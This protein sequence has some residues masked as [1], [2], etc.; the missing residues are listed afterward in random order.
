MIRLHL[1]SEAFEQDIRP[2]YMSFFPK[3]EYVFSYG[4]GKPDGSRSGTGTG[5]EPAD[6]GRYLLEGDWRDDGFTL[7]LYRAGDLSGGVQQ[8]EKKVPFAE[9]KKFR[10]EVKRAVSTCEVSLLCSARVPCA[11]TGYFSS[12][13]PGDSPAAAAAL[14]G[15]PGVPGSAPGPPPA[16]VPSFSII[17]RFWET[18][19]EKGPHSFPG[20]KNP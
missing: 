9:R 1:T 20:R 5:D 15:G 19:N 11:G 17:S 2:L 16:S 14:S 6:W 8:E 13:S 4:A 3:E 18:C 12:V 10:D 7:C